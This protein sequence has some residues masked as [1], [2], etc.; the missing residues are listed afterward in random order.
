MITT[1]I[2]AAK[3]I[4]TTAQ[5]GIPRVLVDAIEGEEIE[6]VGDGAGAGVVIAGDAE[7]CSKG[8]VTLC[9]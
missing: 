1:A 8:L 9:S 7:L 6:K 4:S 2:T 5:T 3:Q